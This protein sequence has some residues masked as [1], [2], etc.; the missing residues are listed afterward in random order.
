MAGRP[1][2]EIDPKTVYKLARLHC[3]HVEIADILGC[4][5]DTLDNR[6]GDLI[7]KGKSETK[8]S[9]RDKQIEMALSGNIPMLIFLGKVMLGQIEPAVDE[10]KQIK[11][12]LIR[13]D[14]SRKP[15]ND[16]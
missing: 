16:K 8:Q 12:I 3:T 1:K 6:F 9:I 4:S 14:P 10:M 13:I 2:S 7:K 11:E 5:V 15:A